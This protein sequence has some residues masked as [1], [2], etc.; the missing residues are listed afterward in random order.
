MERLRTLMPDMPVNFKDLQYFER[1]GIVFINGKN[2]NK[3]HIIKKSKVTIVSSL[4]MDGEEVTTRK[5]GINIYL[6]EYDGA[7]D[8]KRPGS[9]KVALVGWPEAK[10]MNEAVL[11]E[12]IMKK[13][14]KGNWHWVVPTGLHSEMGI[15]MT[16]VTDDVNVTTDKNLILKK[17]KEVYPAFSLDVL[18]D[19]WSVVYCEKYDNYRQNYETHLMSAIEEGQMPLRP[20]SIFYVGEDPA[21]NYYFQSDD[22]PF[23]HV[24][25]D[26]STGEMNV[27]HG[28]EYPQIKIIHLGKTPYDIYLSLMKSAE[29]PVLV[30]GDAS[31]SQAIAFDKLFFY[32]TSAW[33]NGVIPSY[34]EFAIG[35]FAP[36]Q[37]AM[38]RRLH[39]RDS[40]EDVYQWFDGYSK[41][42]LSG[43][44]SVR[45]LAGALR[46]RGIKLPEGSELEIIGHINRDVLTDV[47]L[48]EKYPELNIPRKDWDYKDK[49]NKLSER[50]LIRFNRSLIDRGDP[51][52]SPKNMAP[53]RN[54]FNSIEQWGWDLHNKYKKTFQRL[55]SG[56]EFSDF[57]ND[58]KMMPIKSQLKQAGIKD[59]FQIRNTYLAG[60][61]DFLRADIPSD[62]VDEERRMFRSRVFF[63][64]RAIESSIFN[65]YAPLVFYDE[66]YQ[67]VVHLL[68]Q[69]IV[70]Q[71][72]LTS[73]LMDKIA[74][75]VR[76][77]DH[78]FG[79]VQKEKSGIKG[80]ID[81]VLKKTL[82]EVQNAGDA[83]KFR[84]DPARLEQLRN[85][86]GFSPIIINIQPMTD[87]RLFLG[88]KESRKGAAVI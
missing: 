83:I 36:D 54:D 64:S 87:L 32:E 59:A 16:E 82:L 2:V 52:Q 70:H 4:M 50:E 55:F 34:L 42:V 22:Q 23:S 45:K 39:G 41:D 31:L 35:M 17:L 33:K 47:N 40:R 84:I 62:N 18:G 3:D 56:M 65:Q 63:N 51:Q 67:N 88:L 69:A 80:G 49:I 19:K 1:N 14:S 85:A 30:R 66:R 72:N 74:S 10:A 78:E 28:K 43:E 76:E 61:A 60:Y 25:F 75:M 20:I 38:I 58:E 7:R 77:Y 37:V 68:N 13:D 27:L 21:L 9:S 48:E 24:F 15:Y 53:N 86:P 6:Q 5:S 46:A 79:I 12:N 26:R 81:F 44:F 71:K 29:L 11:K 73:N 8:L 57:F